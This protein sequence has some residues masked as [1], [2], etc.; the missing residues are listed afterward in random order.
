MHELLARFVAA[1]QRGID[2]EVAALRASADA[3]EVPL[4]GGQD[5][6]ALRYDFELPAAVERLAVGAVA[7]LR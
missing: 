4:A 7:V 3:L 5:L 1:F 6:G 2:G